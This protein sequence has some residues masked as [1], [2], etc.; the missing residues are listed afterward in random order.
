[1]VFVFYRGNGIRISS[2][3][4]SISIGYNFY[5]KIP[6]YIKNTSLHKTADT[7]K[8]NL[9]RV[10]DTVIDNLLL[11]FY[12]PIIFQRVTINIPPTKNQPHRLI[13]KPT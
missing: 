3:Q 8:V 10:R 5:L 6:P 4:W 13:I 12:L 9:P 7:S 2:E 1:M 11:S